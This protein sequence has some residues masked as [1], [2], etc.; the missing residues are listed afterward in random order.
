MLQSSTENRVYSTE[1]ILY[2]N[3]LFL[4]AFKIIATYAIQ[5]REG[6]GEERRTS[7]NGRIK[8]SGALLRGDQMNE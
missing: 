6:G 8:S 4:P 1:V 2:G 3:F 7:Q 5:G